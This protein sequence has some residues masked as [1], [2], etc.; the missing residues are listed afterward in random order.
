MRFPPLS[1]VTDA[2]LELAVLEEVHLLEVSMV[3]L[4]GMAVLVPLKLVLVLV[5]LLLELVP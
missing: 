5:L 4:V 3:V 1:A 2:T